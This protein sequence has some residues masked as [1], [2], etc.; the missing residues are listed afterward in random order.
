MQLSEGG[1]VLAECFSPPCQKSYRA[2]ELRAV[3]MFVR[4]RSHHNGPGGRASKGPGLGPKYNF[5]NS[6]LIDPLPLVISLKDFTAFQNS[7]PI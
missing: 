6:A 4:A 5:Q 7:S 2:A 3:G 1:F